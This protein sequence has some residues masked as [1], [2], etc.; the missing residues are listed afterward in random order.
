ME[1]SFFCPMQF[2]KRFCKY[3]IWAFM[4]IV[5]TTNQILKVILSYNLMFTE[6]IHQTD[7]K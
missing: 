1:N 7:R 3:G 5:Y 2:S 4:S 6:G